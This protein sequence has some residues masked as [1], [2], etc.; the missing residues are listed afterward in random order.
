MA[1]ALGRRVVLGAVGRTY[2]YFNG[3]GGVGILTSRGS[4]AARVNGQ[5]LL[6]G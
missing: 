5:G 6:C 4:S 1:K 3:E 2:G